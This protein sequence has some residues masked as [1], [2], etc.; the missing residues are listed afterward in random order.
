MELIN[1]NETLSNKTYFYSDFLT[2]VQNFFKNKFNLSSNDDE[3]EKKVTISFSKFKHGR[4]LS[5]TFIETNGDSFIESSCSKES[6]Y[7]MYKAASLESDKCS[8][9][10]L[11]SILSSQSLTRLVSSPSDLTKND[12]TMI[13]NYSLCFNKKQK[14]LIINISSIEN[15]SLSKSDLSVYVK[16]ELNFLE[17]NKDNSN[18]ENTRTGRTRSIKKQSNPVFEETFEFCLDKEMKS[19]F[20]ESKKSIDDLFKIT[21][22]VCN[23]NVYGRDQI[24]AQHIHTLTLKD[25][26][27]SEELVILQKDIEL[28]ENYHGSSNLYQI[29]SHRA[30]FID[31][32]V[33]YI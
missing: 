13:M 15:I 27:Q 22:N 6:R 23:S 19:L 24:I 21:F 11:K 8:V 4:Q 14:N 7:N 1:D 16:I 12:S 2:K 28:N 30:N 31:S 33:K 10:S 26:L 18:N 17:S 9:S 20:N 29:F 5:D 32:N 3:N 25:L